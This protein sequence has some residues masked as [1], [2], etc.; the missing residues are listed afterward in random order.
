MIVCLYVHNQSVTETQDCDFFYFDFFTNQ[1]H[2]CRCHCCSS[3]LETLNVVV[4]VH[5]QVTLLMFKGSPVISC[6][7]M[8]LSTHVLIQY[9]ISEYDT[10][11]APDWVILLK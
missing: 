5:L 1:K 10:C 2:C 11:T 3:M 8:C 4:T 7:V 6:H 9:L